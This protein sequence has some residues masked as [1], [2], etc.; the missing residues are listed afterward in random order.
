MPKQIINIGQTPNDKHG[1]P[2]RVAFDKVNT[3]F[4]ELYDLTN[5]TRIEELIQD[6][7]SLIITSGTHDGISASYNDTLNA[8]N[9]TVQNQNQLINGD[10][11]TRLNSTGSLDFITVESEVETVIGTLTPESIN[12]TLSL[13]LGTTWQNT[14]ITS[15]QL[16]TGTY[17]IQLYAN[18]LLSGGNNDNEYYSGIMSWYSGTSTYLAD[19]PPE[20]IVLH[21]AGGSSTPSI[22]LRT[23]RAN[24]TIQLQIYS[25]VQN[26]QVAD[27]ILKFKKII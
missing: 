6:T 19:L 18:D 11:I 14:G 2:I 23:Q 27:Y 13:T 22:S 24:T 26:T 10:Y 9:L 7:A 1:D 15:V 3:N 4:T 5:D 12:I 17:I 25:S 16:S 20:D 21:K 8:L